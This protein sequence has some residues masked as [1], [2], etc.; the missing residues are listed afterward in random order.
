MSHRV[1]LNLD[2]FTDINFHKYKF[3]GKAFPVLV[4]I[5]TAV[6]PFH[7]LSPSLAQFNSSPPSAIYT[8]IYIYNASVN[9]VS[10]GSHNGLAPNRCWVIVN[11]PWLRN[12][13]QW[14]FIE[15]IKLK[16]LKI[17]LEISFAK[18]HPLLTA[19]L[20]LSF[21]SLSFFPL[22]VLSSHFLFCLSFTHLQLSLP[23]PLKPGVYLR[24]KM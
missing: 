2:I 11:W 7:C 14:N 10:I 19:C 1:L 17:H 6:S 20:F 8:Y 16:C 15:N 23:N 18:L 4:F 5:F 22:C 12:K 21:P 24:M 13:L 9:R 3:S